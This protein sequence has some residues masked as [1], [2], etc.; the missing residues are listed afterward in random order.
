[1]TLSD[2]ITVF[3][4][5]GI[6][7]AE[8]GPMCDRHASRG[9]VSISWASYLKCIAPGGPT[10]GVSHTANNVLQFW[11]FWEHTQS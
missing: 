3:Q 7:E 9:F 4:C 6:S 11:L 2:P 8:H 1:M 5:H 10:T